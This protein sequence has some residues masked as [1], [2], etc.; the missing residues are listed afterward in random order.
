MRWALTEMKLENVKEKRRA[1]R[2]NGPIWFG[3]A[4]GKTKKLCKFLFSLFEYETKV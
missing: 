2:A 4:R 3:L 1:A